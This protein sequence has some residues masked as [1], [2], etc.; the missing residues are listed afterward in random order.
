MNFLVISRMWGCC[1]S[2]SVR[3]LLLWVSVGILISRIILI[4][5]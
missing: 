1:D 5:L 3:F 2:Q 4:F